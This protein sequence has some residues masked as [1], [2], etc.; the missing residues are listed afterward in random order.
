V[1]ARRRDLWPE[2]GD[3]LLPRLSIYYNRRAR[4]KPRARDA[5]CEVA[6]SRVLPR[7]AS[8]GFLGDNGKRWEF[9]L[10]EANFGAGTTTDSTGMGVRDFSACRVTKQ[11][12]TQIYL[13]G[14]PLTTIKRKNRARQR[15]QR[16]AQT[17]KKHRICS[18]VPIRRL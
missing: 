12:V 8:E 15:S 5:G 14:L 9:V 7:A 2:L 17:P 13:R 18:S 1:A 10:S 16:I 4:V 6:S 11:N 3:Y